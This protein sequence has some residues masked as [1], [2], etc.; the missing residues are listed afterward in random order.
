M[1]KAIAPLISS[2]VLIG[3]AIL[4][5]AVVMSWGKTGTTA[6]SEKR[7]C[8]DASLDIIEI[9]DEKQLCYEDGKLYFTIENDGNVYLSG[10]VVSIIGDEIEQQQV[11]R[12]IDIAS[13]QQIELSY[14]TKIKK[15]I[16]VPIIQYNGK[17]NICAK[18][19]LEIEGVKEC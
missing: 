13:I 9:A 15:L 10:M 7:S 14:K 12:L 18:N 17:A 5:G 4:L 6:L 3:F 11:N 2:I 19:S 16:I 8:N 1:K